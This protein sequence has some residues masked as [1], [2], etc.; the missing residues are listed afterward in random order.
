[1][2]PLVRRSG[3]RLSVNF[4]PLPS[5]AWCVGYSRAAGAEFSGRGGARVYTQNLLVPPEVLLRFAN[6]PR[7]LLRRRARAKELLSVHDP[8]PSI[9]AP[10]QLAGR[11]AAVDEGLI[12]ELVER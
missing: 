5:G 7:A 8:V 12:G 2:I 11:A 10:L 9:L 1:M 4:H 3:W 6:N